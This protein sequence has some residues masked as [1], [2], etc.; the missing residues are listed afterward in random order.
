[1]TQLALG[2]VISVVP[3]VFFAA[4][5]SSLAAGDVGICSVS[6]A[7]LRADAGDIIYNEAV[8]EI[9]WVTFGFI[10]SGLSDIQCGKFSSS[11]K[12]AQTFA[13]RH[14]MITLFTM[15][16]D[17]PYGTLRSHSMA[18]KPRWCWRKKVLPIRLKQESAAPWKKLPEILA[19]PLGKV[20]WIEDGELVLYDST[21][22][23]EYLNE[24]S[25]N[26]PLL[27]ADPAQRALARALE[28]YA[29]EGVLSKPCR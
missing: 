10:W 28:N 13:G 2:G 17:Y 15:E 16:R 24:K 14:S 5:A 23:N 26:N 20:P 29:D 1:M 27:P 4:A 18:A 3:L 9:R 25:A 7:E 8:P 11:S 21:V 22:I 12:T 6:G 19:K